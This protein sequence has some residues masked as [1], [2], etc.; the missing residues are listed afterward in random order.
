L[1]S[2]RSTNMAK[3]RDYPIQLRPQRRFVFVV[4]ALAM[5][6]RGST[7]FIPWSTKN[8]PYAPTE[9]RSSK[10]DIDNLRESA[11]RLRKEAKDMEDGLADKRNAVTNS[12]PGGVV[13]PNYKM[14]ADSTWTCTY[15]FSSDPRKDD[16][17]AATTEGSN[18]SGKYT[19]SF[20]ADGYTDLIS[21]EP[22][23]AS[24]IAI[25]KVWGWD[26]E[27]SNDDGLAYILFS[28]SV[29]LPSN[30]KFAPNKEIRYYWQARI[31]TASDAGGGLTLQ[32]GTVTVKKDIG[33]PGGGFWG[34]ISG[35]GILAQFRYVGNFSA[36]G[37][38][39]P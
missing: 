15:R 38:M 20:K 6:I 33:P 1:Q 13:I 3:S 34:A 12:V 7:A 30:D 37:A 4:L 5:H 10:D 17:N 26:E 29:T 23:G 8:R 2:N 19:V 24:T 21:H 31:D 32:D 9:K 22:S 35:A 16:E 27:V 28:T 39:R 18:Y 36:K 25:E 11:E 14:L